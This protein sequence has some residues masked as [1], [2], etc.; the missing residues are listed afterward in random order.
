MMKRKFQ[1]RIALPVF[2]AALV[3]ITAVLIFL[4][5]YIFSLSSMDKVSRDYIGNVGSL[6]LE[7]TLNHLAPA[8]KLA[9]IN[10]DLLDPHNSQSDY[11][12][13]FNRV[14]I[15]QLNVYPQVTQTYIADTK[16]NFLLNT[17]EKDGSI[18]SQST[19]RL[20]D[21]EA[22]RSIVATALSMPK[23][24]LEDKAAIAAL[25]TPIIKTSASYRDI[26]G[27]PSRT[28]V[29]K[30]SV[31]DPRLRPWF[32]AAVKKKSTTWTP[33]YLF[34]S[35]GKHFASGQLGITAS[36]P[37]L[38]AQAFSDLQGVVGVDI[39]LLELSKFIGSLQIGK[40]GRAFII[41]STGQMIALS[42][43]S[44]VTVTNEAGQTSLANINQSKDA[45]ALLSYQLL[46]SE[47]SE[48][49][50][51]LDVS[52]PRFT[53]FQS[54][55]LNYIGY[56]LPIP[57]EL[58]LDWYI[59]IV[60]PE[61]DFIG[62]IRRN[63]VLSILISGLALLI[64]FLLSIRLS[65]GITQP[66]AILTREALAIREFHVDGSLPLHTRFRELHEMATAFES[67]K[68]GL[69]S[70]R[71]FVPADLVRTL[72][73]SGE[74]ASLGGRRE[75]ITIFFSDIV[76]FTRIAEQMSAEALITHLGEYVSLQSNVIEEMRG[77]V[78]KFIG[79]A[80]MAFWNAPLPVE[81]HALRTCE[82]AL[83]VQAALRAQRPHWQAQGL[84]IFHARIGIE[85]GDV[86]VG[87]M[88]SAK[89]L[90]YTVIG[91]TVN[92]A[93]RLESLGKF[94]QVSILIGE[95]AFGEAGSGIEARWLDRVIL[96]GKSKAI[97]IYELLAKKGEL[98]EPAQQFRALYESALLEYF[99]QRWEAADSLFA[100]AQQLQ[101]N[102]HACTLMRARCAEFTLHPPADN[103]NGAFVPDSK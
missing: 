71:K 2:F 100:Q 42:D 30:G 3:T 29:L 51:V 95:V 92:Q 4:V 39:T 67:M 24:S 90:N 10:A 13:N 88:G 25:V 45:A 52:G 1:L 37:I 49:Q 69:R 9:S 83:A 12:K 40:T 35:T 77:T 79:D 31:Y 56:F 8:A 17:R 70:F 20:R 64:V 76:G 102:D 81:Q 7:K 41:N 19:T 23:V 11:L 26:D 16:G 62:D 14:T 44:K 48:H 33:A 53:K 86:V 32:K 59:G 63:L 87:N 85:T 98:G 66:L 47:T 22:A 18:A 89:R 50:H 57:E 46:A 101:A 96:M 65:K 5:N 74:E 84:P 103:W 6:V 72:V 43:Y 55:G 28:E 68:A 15:G 60:V 36:S 78:D 97:N 27:Q 54:A 91:D 34:S 21:D 82:A 94:Y 73:Q 80:I 99:A 58:G 75:R 61:D 38:G 93:S